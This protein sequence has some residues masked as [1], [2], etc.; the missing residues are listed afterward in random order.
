MSSKFETKEIEMKVEP[1]TFLH[2]FNSSD[3]IFKSFQVHSNPVG[4]RRKLNA[5]KTS[6]DA[7]DVLCV[8]G[9]EF[10]YLWQNVQLLMN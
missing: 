10:F 9:E 6:E 7:Q 5:H 4:A 8:Y 1:D 3:E 2:V